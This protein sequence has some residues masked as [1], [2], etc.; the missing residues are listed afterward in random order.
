MEWKT[1]PQ[2]SQNG[3]PV[4]MDVPVSGA[5]GIPL[6]YDWVSYA[7]VGGY[8]SNPPQYGSLPLLDSGSPVGLSDKE[9]AYA[10][11]TDNII[12]AYVQTIYIQPQQSDDDSHSERKKYRPFGW[13]TIKHIILCCIT[14]Y[15]REIPPKGNVMRNWSELGSV[16]IKR[17]LCRGTNLCAKYTV[18]YTIQNIIRLS[19][20]WTR[21]QVRTMN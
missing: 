4:W 19:D 6:F 17:T 18:I 8:S 7:I 20:V 9:H 21:I 15:T 14:C 1:Y 2:Y 11:T 13:T 3:I 12:H 16:G 10:D 5:A